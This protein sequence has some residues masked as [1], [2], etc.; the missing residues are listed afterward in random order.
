[1]PTN[2]A[3]GAAARTSRAREATPA[4]PPSTVGLQRIAPPRRRARG[5]RATGG[6]LEEGAP[7]PPRV[8]ERAREGRRERRARKAA[9]D[10]LSAGR[11]ESHVYRA[12]VARVARAGASGPRPAETRGTP[13]RHANDEGC[14]WR[15]SHGSACLG[16]GRGAT[17][18]GRGGGPRPRC[19][20]AWA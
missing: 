5:A 3:S 16:R 14:A 20:S 12:I 18:A 7:A 19:P 17:R 1:M 8:G 2:G 15:G 10:E 4:G 9:D 6:G 11:Y 13:T